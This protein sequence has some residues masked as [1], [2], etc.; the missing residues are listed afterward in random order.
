MA[1]SSPL[2]VLA[3]PDFQAAWVGIVSIA[4]PERL[5]TSTAAQENQHWK[6]RG[7]CPAARAEP[8]TLV[9][10]ALLDSPNPL[11]TSLAVLIGRL[12]FP[13]R[14]TAVNHCLVTTAHCPSMVLRPSMALRMI[15]MRGIRSCIFSPSLLRQRCPEGFGKVFKKCPRTGLDLRSVPKV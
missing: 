12:T 3:D 2:L 11:H 15:L 1:A 13:C 9:K 14:Q 4:Q 8:L 7:V 5:D 6:Q 10:A